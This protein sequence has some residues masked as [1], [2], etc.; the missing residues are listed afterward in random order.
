MSQV[1]PTQSQTQLLRQFVDWAKA[2]PEW[3]V[4]VVRDHAA[5]NRQPWLKNFN[6]KKWD[7]PVNMAFASSGQMLQLLASCS[8]CLSVS[9][10]WVMVTMIWGRKCLIV[11][12]YGVH[13]E[14]RTT[15][16]F[17]S[18]VM[19]SVNNDQKLSFSHPGVRQSSPTGRHY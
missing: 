4:I 17:G 6:P 8:A 11:G 14:Q 1:E 18:G 10:P 7:I 12:D 5:A 19:Q 13:T 9:S 15:A 16:F 2:A 3:T